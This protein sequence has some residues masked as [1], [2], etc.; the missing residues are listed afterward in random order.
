MCGL[1]R[2]MRARLSAPDRDP[3]SLMNRVVPG[4]TFRR[5]ATLSHDES[6]R[7]ER[8]ARVVATAQYVFDDE[9]DARL[10][11]STPHPELEGARPLDLALR[12]IGARRVEEV[13]ARLFYGLP[14]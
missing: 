7:S 1:L 12:E 3:A 9:R 10:F 6:E 11:L 14:A 8:L 5:R 4:A 13:L 2:F